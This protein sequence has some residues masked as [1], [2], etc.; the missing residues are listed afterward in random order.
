M[1]YYVGNV[2]INLFFIQFFFV[3]FFVNL[4]ISLYL[5][6][7]IKIKV[8]KK[9]EFFFGQIFMKFEWMIFCCIEGRFI[10]WYYYIEYFCDLSFNEY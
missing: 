1:G 9:V 8:C 6:L 5:L 2:M 10:L 7:G 4:E 3:F